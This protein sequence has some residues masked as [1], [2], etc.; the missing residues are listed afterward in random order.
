MC[1]R[2]KQELNHHLRRFIDG[3]ELVSLYIGIPLGIILGY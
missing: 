1:W 2:A 3:L